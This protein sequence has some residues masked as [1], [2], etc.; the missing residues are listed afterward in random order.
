M[1]EIRQQLAALSAEC[2][3]LCE[4]YGWLGHETRNPNYRLL[5]S[6]VDSYEHGSGFAIVGMN[7]AGDGRDADADDLD[8]SFPEAGYS[9]YLDDRWRTRSG[10]APLQRVVQA[11]AMILSGASPSE[12]MTAMRDTTKTPEERVGAKASAFLRNTPSMNIIPFRDS[13]LWK[14]PSRLRERGETIGWRLLCLAHPRPR[15]IVT[16]ANQVS[17]PP[18]RTILRNSGQPQRPDYEETVHEGMARTYREVRLVRGPLEGSLLMGL[19]AIVRDK[20]RRDITEPLFEVV[21][22]RL[23]HHEVF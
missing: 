3:S 19:P 10:A 1:P 12:A 6:S 18:W 20:G 22:R 17:R 16:L 2:D 9:A 4:E 21:S 11:L 7:P 8:C 23:G 15:C 5:Y 14:V 13:N